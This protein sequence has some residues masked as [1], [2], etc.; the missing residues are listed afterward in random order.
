M[1]I[2]IKTEL[3]SDS[4]KGIVLYALTYK[5]FPKLK[6][7]QIEINSKEVKTK[8]GYEDYMNAVDSYFDIL[9]KLS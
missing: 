4:D 8:L 7:W 3:K 1:A 9:A 5:Q 6:E 2:A